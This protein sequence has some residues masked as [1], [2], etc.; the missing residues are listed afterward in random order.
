MA[1]CVYPPPAAL[2]EARCHSRPGKKEEGV[3]RVPGRSPGAMHMRY[4]TQQLVS[5]CSTLPT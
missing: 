3:L 5:K 4:P 1:Q 2:A